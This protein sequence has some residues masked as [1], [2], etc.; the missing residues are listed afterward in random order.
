MTLLIFG[1][2]VLMSG[3]GTAGKEVLS[4]R[5]QASG[6]GLGSGLRLDGLRIR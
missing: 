5:M 4:F 6:C 2:K 3:S 1:E